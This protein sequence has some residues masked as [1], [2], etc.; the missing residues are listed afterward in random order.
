MRMLRGVWVPCWRDV[1]GL[2]AGADSVSWLASGIC[3]TAR[4]SETQPEHTH[5]PAAWLG[6][7]VCAHTP[8]HSLAASRRLR[9]EKSAE[10]QLRKD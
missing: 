1:A 10:L 7:C 5:T 9:E 2:A 6:V 8:T 3:E 4:H